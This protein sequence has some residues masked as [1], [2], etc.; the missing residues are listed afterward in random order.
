ML[1]DLTYVVDRN[2]ADTFKYMDPASSVSRYATLLKEELGCDLVICL[3]HCG[4]DEDLECAKSLKNVDVIVGG[5]SH[6]YIK[7]PAAVRSSDGK[8]III[9]QDGSY[10]LQVGNLKV[11]L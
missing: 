2:V 4:W 1:T 10:G 6:T 9:V 8:N 5:H 11:D 7:E 3:S